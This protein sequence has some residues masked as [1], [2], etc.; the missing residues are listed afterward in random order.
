MS[1]IDSSVYD[2]TKYQHVYTFAQKCLKTNE[3]IYLMI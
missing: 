3:V 2:W 1:D